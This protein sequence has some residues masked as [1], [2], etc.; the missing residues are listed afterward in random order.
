MI[1]LDTNVLVRLVLRDDEAQAQRSRE[2]V[3]THAHSDA[4]LFVSDV[5]LAEFAWAL[6]SRYALPA[7]AIA[8][9]LRAMLDNA[10]LAWQSRAAA[11]EALRLFEQ[12]SVEFPDCLVVAL[13]QS[14]DCEAVATFDQGLRA[15]PKVR[16]L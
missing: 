9:T 8:R 6:R 3:E 13:A 2:L 15:L 1:A 14:H 7:K 10:T 4:S 11:V 5:V 12:G 16:L